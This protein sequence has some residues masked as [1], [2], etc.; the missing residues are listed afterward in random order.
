M[1]SQA[2]PVPASR[3]AP[4][5][6]AHCASLGVPCLGGRSFSLGLT[7]GPVSQSLPVGF[8]WVT[9]PGSTQV[10]ALQ[11]QEEGPPHLQNTRGSRSPGVLRWVPS[12]CQLP[13]P[14]W[15]ARGFLCSPSP[16]G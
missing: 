13:D 3:A 1:R 15:K 2:L 9:G 4:G 14:A 16:A 12:L 5:M 10:W 6:R 7:L 11:A 8:Q